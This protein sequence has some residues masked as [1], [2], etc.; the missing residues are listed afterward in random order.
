M[1]GRAPW[2]F[3]LVAI[4]LVATSCGLPVRVGVEHLR[5]S[6]RAASG[7]AP[8]EARPP[9]AEPVHRVIG[10]AG[11][12]TNPVIPM[13]AAPTAPVRAENAP[14]PVQAVVPAPAPP[15]AP[16][17]PNVVMAPPVPKASGPDDLH[18]VRI[19]GG[20]SATRSLVTFGQ[21]FAPGAVPKG[22][23][24]AAY[25]ASGPVPTQAD[26]KTTHP[27]GSARM[28]VLTVRAD[29]PLDL[30]LRRTGTRAGGA[31]VA[32][33]DLR[34]RY[35]LR[36]TL[37]VHDP[38]PVSEYSANLGT[39]LA[40]SIAAGRVSTWLSGPLVAEARVEVPVT[41]S[42]RLVADIRAH[43]DGVIRTDLQLN[44]DIAMGPDGGPLTYDVSVTAGGQVL[45]RQD[46]IRHHQYQTWH[47]EFWSDGKAEPHVV[48]DPTAL[49]RA[50]AVPPYDLSLGVNG[51]VITEMAAAAAA[52]EPQILGDGGLTR[53]MPTTGGR[54]DIGI[55]T[56]PNAA[57]LVTQ[58]PDAKRYA[59]VQAD[60]AGS[61]PW[62]FHDRATGAAIDPKHH[63]LLWI[64]S[65]GGRWG[66][67]GLTQQPNAEASGW[68]PDTAHQPDLSYVAYVLTGSRYRYDQVE[69]QGLF[70]ILAQAPGY[71]G[72]EKG[73]VVHTAEQVRGKAWAF[74]S[75]EQ[76]AFIA[77]DDAPSR[78][79]L[80]FAVE[81]NIAHLRHEMSWRTVGETYGAFADG[82]PGNWASGATGP[83][84][85][86]YL[87]SVL[88]MAA[89]RGVPG[90]AEAVVWMSNFVAGR[91]TAA[92]KGFR[93]INGT[94]F[95][96]VIAPKN[97]RNPYLT[98]RDVEDANV[99][100]MGLDE[101]G[102]LK[103]NYPAILY[104]AHGALTIM[105]H[106]ADKPEIWKALDWVRANLPGN[107]Q[108][109]F[110]RDPT[111]NLAPMRAR[112]G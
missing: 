5:P 59:L 54:P 32:L 109:E 23:S 80:K 44:N 3:V 16:V 51:R 62:H 39:L 94:S 65:R 100:A 98:W 4:V 27:D 46:D 101:K 102:D 40:R 99:A 73:I 41:G 70:S 69:A 91:F 61:V 79:S 53:Y 30:M 66:T 60:A 38:G 2:R 92:E 106:V 33:A 105:T 9:T 72:L 64:D 12:P 57:W 11:G 85:Q 17:T 15:P 37:T 21:V 90:A 6:A 52:K 56:L 36:V 28:V 43:A 81:N 87:A 24:V 58:H 63:P 48:H 50:G 1:I 55:T 75:V 19:E 84:Q 71:R 26:I 47:R 13:R 103:S 111:W 97:G 74:R 34:D 7:V 20:R 104:Y 83:W 77:P 49:A 31:P 89:M 68:T 10:Q 112:R 93:P 8:I 82:E 108:M 14:Q 42:L 22:M 86:D 29:A 78:V 76:A 96:M 95:Y 45:L 18:G 88:G 107:P 25:A 35:D 67:V 110:R